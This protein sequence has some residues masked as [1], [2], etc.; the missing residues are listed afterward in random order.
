M[1]EVVGSKCIVN[2]V[3]GQY[4]GHME[5]GTGSVLWDLYNWT[6]NAPKQPSF[7]PN[8]HVMEQFLERKWGKIP[9][10]VTFPFN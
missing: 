7:W 6:S 2:K 5:A 4:F 1:E 8:Y 9:L 10:T 3:I